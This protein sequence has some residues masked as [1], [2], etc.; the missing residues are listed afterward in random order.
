V[1]LEW[2]GRQDGSVLYFSAVAEAELEMGAR[3]PAEFDF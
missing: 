2:F 1:I 3:A